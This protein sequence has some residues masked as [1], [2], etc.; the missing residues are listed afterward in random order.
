MK[1][2]EL[3]VPPPLVMLLIGLIMWWVSIIFPGLTFDWLH[4]FAAAII[5]AVLGVIVSLAGVITFRRAGTTIDPRHTEETAVLVNSGIYRYSR[6]PM[7]VGVLLMLLGW[8]VYLGNL[9]S[10]LCTVI[11]I[12]YITRFQIMPEERMLQG[13]F[14]TEFLAYKDRVRRW[15]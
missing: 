9:L 2:L 13:K 1:R 15:L 6:N 3:L 14:G 11:F 7:Y 10:I 8:G 12:A 4:S 5:L